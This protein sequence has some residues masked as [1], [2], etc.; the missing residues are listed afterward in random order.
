MSTALIHQPKPHTKASAHA[1]LASPLRGDSGTRG[2][3]ASAAQY[4]TNTAIAKA[5]L[6]SSENE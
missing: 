3:K 4:A 5:R 1:A 6:A 2:T